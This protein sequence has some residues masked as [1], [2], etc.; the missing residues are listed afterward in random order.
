MGKS[1]LKFVGN[2]GKPNNLISTKLDKGSVKEGCKLFFCLFV[3][4]IFGVYFLDM[5]NVDWCG[6]LKINIEI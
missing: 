3:L 5:G 4:I 6:W 2:S 1:R